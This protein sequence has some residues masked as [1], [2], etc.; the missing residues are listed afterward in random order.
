MLP[1]RVFFF[2]NHIIIHLLSTSLAQNK[3]ALCKGKSVSS[4]LGIIQPAPKIKNPNFNLKL[5]WRKV[6]LLA[7]R[8]YF[9]LVPNRIFFWIGYPVDSSQ[10]FLFDFFCSGLP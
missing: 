7:P 6:I 4:D 3:S 9:L 5:R 1:G 2:F 8:N 10:G